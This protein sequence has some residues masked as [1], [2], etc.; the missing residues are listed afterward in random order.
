[1]ASFFGVSRDT[2]RKDWQARGMPWSPG[3][4]DLPAITKWRIADALRAKTAR[5]DTGDSFMDGDESPGLE[6]YRL[7]K[8]ELAEL[9]LERR[10]GDLVDRAVMRTGLG[11]MADV[12]RGAGERL[13]RVHGA[14]PAKV[15]S[16]AL[17]GV[18]REI[19]T[20]FGESES[21]G[22]VTDDPSPHDD[23]TS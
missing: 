4:F 15:L 23:R 19:E 7:A 13:E 18:E 12:L 1:M 8:A 11:R 17:K 10:K 5:D 20:V 22:A 3:K 21:D 6:R 2:I 14:E 9:E 16:D